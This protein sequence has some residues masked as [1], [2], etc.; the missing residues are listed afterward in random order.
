MY[1]ILRK[2]RGRIS[3]FTEHPCTSRVLEKELPTQLLGGV[4]LFID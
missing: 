4:P 2:P 3:C 1:T